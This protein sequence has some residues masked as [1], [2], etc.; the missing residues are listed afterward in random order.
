MSLAARFST[1]TDLRK[2]RPWAE[3]PPTIGPN[4]RP[5]PWPFARSI[6]ASVGTTPV[7]TPTA[8]VGE[9][10]ADATRYDASAGRDSVVRSP[11][12]RVTCW[13]TW[14]YRPY[15]PTPLPPIARIRSSPALPGVFGV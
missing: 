12:T 6:G 9:G 2:L 11:L 7:G 8:Y 5:W 14:G 1:Q 4:L 3:N 10:M 15:R 13:P